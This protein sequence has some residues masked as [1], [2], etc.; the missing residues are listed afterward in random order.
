M[1]VA[2]LL[3]VAIGPGSTTPQTLSLVVATALVAMSGWLDDHRPLPVAPRLIAQIAAVAVLAFGLGG[4]S[5]ASVLL[6]AFASLWFVNL[7]NF[8]DGTD[9]LAAAEAVF[10][11]LGL[12]YFSFAANLPDIAWLSAALA[13]AMAGFV[14]WNWPPAR[15]FLGD[16]GSGVGGTVLAGAAWW[17]WREG[18][19]AP[20]TVLILAG[21]FFVDA[22]ATLAA[23]AV[24]GGTNYHAPS[25]PRLSTRGP[26]LGARP[27]GA[28][29]L[30]RQYHLAVARG[31]SLPAL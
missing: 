30:S 20:A 14:P 29:I 18:A 21:T 8:M 23:R 31:A 28:G 10:C 26:T 7:F 2:W 27:G 12:T 17:C 3:A 9:L 6:A 1:L 13:V 15:L 11:A 24:A 4:G 22:T 25:E 19:I 16:V 5:W